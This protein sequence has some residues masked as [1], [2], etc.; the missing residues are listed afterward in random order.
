MTHTEWHC[1]LCNRRYLVPPKGAI[2]CLCCTCDP[3]LSKTDHCSFRTIWLGDPA[4]HARSPIG[5]EPS[6]ASDLEPIAGRLG[7]C[8]DAAL[9]GREF[10][11][12]LEATAGE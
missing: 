8:L 2:E 10:P 5:V 4:L 11:T 3:P 12:E 6:I 9:E 7:I 1:P